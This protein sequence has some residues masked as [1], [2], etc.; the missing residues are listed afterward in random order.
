MKIFNFVVVIMMVLVLAACSGDHH[1]THYE[2]GEGNV[3]GY[4]IPGLE[5]GLVQSP[6]NILSADT[7][8]GHHNIEVNY[9]G[10]VTMVENKGHTVQLDF[11]P[12][13]T[14]RVDG[15]TYDMIQC[16]FHTPSEHLIDGMTFPM[17]MHIVN[18]LQGQSEGDT[19]SYLVI[20]YMY[21]M[22]KESDFLRRFIE[23]IPEEAGTTKEVALTTL[24]GERTPQ[25]VLED[26]TH[27]YHYKGSLT[28][29]PYT[30]SVEWYVLSKIHEASPEQIMRINTIEGD[31]AR[32][33]QGIYGREI[34]Q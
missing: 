12:G 13:S 1:T 16:H 19:P 10:M 27:Y 8:A 7:K 34:D 28:T 30:E 31:N 20:G 11:E 21:K 15:K 6:I 5:H 24:F 2:H 18:R 22:G 17:E 4:L 9:S 32:H 14:V 23:L 29:P 25:D 26:W 33:I 3:H